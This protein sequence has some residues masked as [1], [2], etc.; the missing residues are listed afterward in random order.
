MISRT[1]RQL[2]GRSRICLVLC[3]GPLIIFP[4]FVQPGAEAIVIFA[5]AIIAA[6]GFWSNAPVTGD[7]NRNGDGL[8]T[9]GRGGLPDGDLRS[10]G[11]HPISETR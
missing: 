3:L 5:I 7:R 8:N 1:L 6:L 9:D 11:L 4:V 10:A 2:L